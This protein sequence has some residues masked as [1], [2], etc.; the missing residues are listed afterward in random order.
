MISK[1]H[2]IFLLFVIVVSIAGCGM[3][4]SS[5]LI[6]SIRSDDIDSVK[7]MIDSGEDVNASSLDIIEDRYWKLTPLIRASIT[8]NVEIIK[9]LL[10]A[11]ADVNGKD[12][13][14]DT[15]LMASSEYNHIEAT[16]LLI[17][18]GAD[19]DAI[20][21]DQ[22][23]ALM[24]SARNGNYEIAHILLD[25]NADV[26]IGLGVGSGG[27]ALSLALQRR[28]GALPKL[29]K[30][31]NTSI[32]KAMID[33]GAD[34]NQK[35]KDGRTLLD[36]TIGELDFDIQK[37][38][39]ESGTDISKGYP[40]HFAAFV[41][42]T[43]LVFLLVQHGID[44][45]KKNKMKGKKN[46]AIYNWTALHTAAAFHRDEIVRILLEN[47]AGVDLLTEN[48]ETPLL[49]AVKNKNKESAEML[50]NAGA[51]INLQNKDK[52]S[53]LSIAKETGRNDIVKLLEDSGAKE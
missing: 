46:K 16:K 35:D 43:D 5:P 33:K 50:I 25:A 40:L 15:A 31:K 41:G 30:E 20:K 44:V 19:V 22:T 2:S 53:P 52:R 1:L 26:N 45:N 4:E 32:I 28:T 38:L 27:T 11:G 6:V 13:F 18:S 21:P 23:T 34:L 17:K 12:E 39:I 8:G 29:L 49:L 24:I 10:E 36:R 14:G 37:L 51:D 47:G 3:Y 42:E 7:S 48:G 9:L